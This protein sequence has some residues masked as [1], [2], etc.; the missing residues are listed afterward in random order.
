[1]SY[2]L[3]NVNYRYTELNI[4]VRVRRV[5]IPIPTLP[6]TDSAGI[7]RDSQAR[8]CRQGFVSRILTR[9][10]ALFFFNNKYSGGCGGLNNVV[11]YLS[12]QVQ[13]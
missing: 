9:K 3:L 2:T 13:L 10:C 8:T 12:G 6:G 11:A 1:M 5:V 7:N 4:A